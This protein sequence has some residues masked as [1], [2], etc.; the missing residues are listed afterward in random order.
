MTA[1]D[2]SGEVDKVAERHNQVISVDAKRLPNEVACP[3]AS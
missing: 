3:S 1:V 2:D